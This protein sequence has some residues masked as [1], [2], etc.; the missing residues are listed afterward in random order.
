MSNENNQNN[1]E[2]KKDN[3]YNSNK[4]KKGIK[5]AFYFL[6]EKITDDEEFKFI[7]EKSVKNIIPN[8]YLASSEGRIYDTFS[9]REVA[10]NYDKKGV[11]RDGT[12]KG[13]LYSSIKI[14]NEDG[15]IESKRCRV[16]RMVA[17]TFDK[18]QNK[19]FSK[20]EVDHLNN[21]H[22]DNSLDNLE[23]VTKAE[24]K[25]RAVENNLYPAGEDHCCAKFSNDQVRE[26]AQLISDGKDNKEISE[27]TGIEPE[28]IRSIRRRDSY[29]CVTKDFVFP[30]IPKL[31]ITDELII[32]IADMITQGCTQDQICNKLGVT[33]HLISKVRTKSIRP[34][35]L[36]NYD[37]TKKYIG[38]EKEFII[39]SICKDL[40]SGMT[41]TEVKEKYNGL[42]DIKEIDSY[43][44]S[45]LSGHGYTYISQNYNIPS[46]SKFM[47]DELVTAICER[48]MDND[49]TFANIARE[50]G[51][52]P[53][54]VQDIHCKKHYKHIT[55]NYNFPVYK[56][57]DII[58][59]ELVEKI[60]QML[61]DKV[62]PAKIAKELN[63]PVGIIYH[64][65]YRDTH[66]DIS[67]KYNW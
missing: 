66:T 34:D 10:Q 11:K 38:D 46:F 52:E 59:K 43:V 63:A 2:N 44:S 17:I 28:Y 64:I 13:Y 48:I 42:Y 22:S 21:N 32:S 47:S 31:E 57:P 35:L 19:D 7:D 20:L 8:R 40:E 18:D 24:N 58:D 56:N 41:P 45:V 54:V 51:I 62:S 5:R 49:S 39:N 65:K 25:K 14:R 50:F 6:P 16:N 9:E 23:I 15:I 29:K 53:S 4:Q 36:E 3:R 27:I 12:P 37:F 26:V 1:N 30:E 61:Q 60:C 67:S 55:E 33:I